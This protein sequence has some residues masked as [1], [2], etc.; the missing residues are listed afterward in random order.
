M[1]NAK[2]T[3]PLKQLLKIKRTVYTV[4]GEDLAHDNILDST[5]KWEQENGWLF[6]KM[7]QDQTAQHVTTKPNTT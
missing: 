4:Q 3:V 7:N 1:T 2:V 5:E 6:C